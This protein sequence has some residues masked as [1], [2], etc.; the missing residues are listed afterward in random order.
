MK[1]FFSQSFAAKRPKNRK[2]LASFALLT[3]FIA[4]REHKEHIDKHL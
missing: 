3:L 2:K 1:D 4:T